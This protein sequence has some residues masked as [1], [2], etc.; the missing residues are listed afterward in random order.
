MCLAWQVG[1]SR[2]DVRA[3][4][5]GATPSN[6]GQCERKRPFD[7]HPV[8][9]IQETPQ[10]AAH[11]T[12]RH[13]S[14]TEALSE[15]RCIDSHSKLNGTNERF[16]KMNQPLDSRQ[17]RAFVTLAHTGSFTLTAKELYLSQSAVSHSI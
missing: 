10:E 7:H 14:C 17:L 4:C 15:M 3:A 13:K 8:S 6:A 12:D 11:F 2:C 9:H 5:S 1:T 16:W